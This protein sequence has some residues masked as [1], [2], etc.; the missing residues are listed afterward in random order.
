MD[1]FT[2]YA[3]QLAGARPPGNHYLQLAELPPTT[4]N[5][6]PLLILPERASGTAGIVQT[7][8]ATGG[9]LVAVTTVAP[10]GHRG[11]HPRGVSDAGG[12]A[13]MGI[14]ELVVHAF[15]ILSAHG[16]DYQAEARVCR[17]V[18]DRLFPTAARTEDPWH[19]LLAATGRTAETRGQ[20]W[21]W[22]SSV[23]HGVG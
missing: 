4:E 12:F 10:P 16:V 18:L 2:Y 19:D 6:P 1:D 20:L 15:D 22:D 8:D 7:L 21:V 9:L 14:T 13:A 17:L 5:G 23:H 3:L 11:Y